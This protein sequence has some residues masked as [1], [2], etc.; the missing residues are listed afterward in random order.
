MDRPD[1]AAT[2]NAHRRGGGLIPRATRTGAEDGF[3]ARVVHLFEHDRAERPATL[4]KRERNV[5]S[6]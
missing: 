1:A 2:G 4:A 5:Q 3:V 6:R